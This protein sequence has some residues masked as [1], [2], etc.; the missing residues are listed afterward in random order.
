MHENWHLMSLQHRKLLPYFRRF[1]I[2]FKMQIFEEEFFQIKYISVKEENLLWA[3]LTSTN[4]RNS[5]YVFFSTDF[6]RSGRKK[7]VRRKLNSS[8]VTENQ[9]Q[10][11]NMAV[12]M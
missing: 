4:H 1:E 7:T 3:K 8:L 9:K 11:K 12:G 10:L 5:K 6:L 2:F